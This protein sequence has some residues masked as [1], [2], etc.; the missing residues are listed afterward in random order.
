MRFGISC[1][2]CEDVGRLKRAL[3]DYTK[4]ESSDQPRTRTLNVDCGAWSFATSPKPNVDQTHI[5][6]MTLRSSWKIVHFHA[7]SPST[8]VG[9]IREVPNVMPRAITQEC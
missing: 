6:I 1:A 5:E 2:R 3:L 9:Y 7:S 8:I 4:T